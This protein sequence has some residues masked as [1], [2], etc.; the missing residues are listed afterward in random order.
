MPGF[1]RARDYVVFLDADDHL[2]PGKLRHQ[3][4]ILD[5]DHGADAVYGRIGIGS[6][7]RGR[8]PRAPEPPLGAL[9]R[10]I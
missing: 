4:A 8:R 5:G 6:P 9:G 10:D 3:V 2:P 1:E 7:V